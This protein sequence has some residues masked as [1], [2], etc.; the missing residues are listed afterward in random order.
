M[1]DYKSTVL[2]PW[3]PVAVQAVSEIHHLHL[4]KKIDGIGA[5]LQ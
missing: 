4:Q 1:H 5:E 3:F 2:P